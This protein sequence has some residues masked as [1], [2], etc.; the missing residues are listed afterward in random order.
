MIPNIDIR[1]ATPEDAGTLFSLIHEFAQHEGLPIYISEA[2]LR[3]DGFGNSPQF[4][5]IIAEHEGTP[6]GYA[7]FFNYYSTFRGPGL[8]LEDLY[9]RKEFRGQHVGHAMLRHLAELAVSED[10]F[11]VML[12]VQNENVQ[13]LEFY[14]HSNATVLEERRVLCLYRDAL[15]A[16]LLKVERAPKPR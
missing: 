13:A 10:C 16:Y 6:V 14:R 15:D 8:F 7:C 3:H 11:G 5:A 2:R 9:V 1:F 12:H 4:R